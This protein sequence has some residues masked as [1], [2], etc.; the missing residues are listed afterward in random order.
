MRL[1]SEARVAGEGLE[2]IEQWR[3]KKEACFCFFSTVS[4]VS[5]VQPLFSLVICSDVEKKGGSQFQGR[6]V[7]SS[8]S[9]YVIKT[10][11]KG[12][13]KFS[14]FPCRG[15][16]RFHTKQR[17]DT[18]RTFHRLL[19]DSTNFFVIPQWQFS[20]CSLTAHLR[21]VVTTQRR[22]PYG[23][24]FCS[25]WPIKMLD[26]GGRAASASR[27]LLLGSLCMKS[28]A[29]LQR[30]HTLTPLSRITDSQRV[31]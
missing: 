9:L 8:E 11:F 14:F 29:P 6:V 16:G 13:K 26:W 1:L 19:M 21:T 2:F 20:C 7:T 10:D 27:T 23:A 12:R 4:T 18:N 22:N 17:H 28:R 31:K 15:L 3:K 30:R 24:S 5:C 25:F